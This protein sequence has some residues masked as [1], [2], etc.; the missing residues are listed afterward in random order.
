MKQIFLLIPALC[1]VYFS[2][3][4]QGDKLDELITAYAKL[5]KFNGSALVAKNGTILLKKGYGYRNAADKV[6]NNEQTIFQ[7]G[8]ITKQ[9]TSAVIL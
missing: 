9:F 3:S 8:S 5:Y 6:A 4:Q 1:I 7:L 2:F